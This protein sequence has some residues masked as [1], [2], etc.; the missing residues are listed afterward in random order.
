MSIYGCDEIVNRSCNNCPTEEPNKIVAVA[1]VDKGTVI[2]TSDPQ[3]F[4]DALLAAEQLDVAQIIRQMSGSYD[5]GTVVTG[6]GPGKTLF[7]SIGGNHVLTVVD[8]DYVSN[9][10]F[11]NGMEKV[12]QYFDLYFFTSNYGWKIDGA[13]ISVEP[14]GTIT[15]DL[16]SLIAPPIEIKWSKKGRPLPYL[17]NVDDLLE[18]P[19]AGTS[20]S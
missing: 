13:F 14:K 10:E 17:A 18:C 7:R 9:A 11:W 20:G 16:N 4:V 1:F 12:G 3:A 2:D 6:P 5:G 15:D 8:Y 19:D